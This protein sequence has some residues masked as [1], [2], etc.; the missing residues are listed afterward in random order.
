MCFTILHA[1]FY[2]NTLIYPCWWY[3]LSLI[4]VLIEFISSSH[5]RNQE[6]QFSIMAISPNII[7]SSICT[8]MYCLSAKYASR[9][10]DIGDGLKPSTCAVHKLW[11]QSPKAGDGT[12][13]MRAQLRVLPLRAWTV[14]LGCL[15]ARLMGHVSY[16]QISTSLL[17]Q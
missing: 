13:I 8:N 1:N 11:L 12:T 4:C 9:R 17:S 5:D 14:G 7:S 3:N 15:V 2:I 6:D 10:F 16:E